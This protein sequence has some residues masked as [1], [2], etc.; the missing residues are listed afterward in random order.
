MILAA[1]R[2]RTRPERRGPYGTTLGVSADTHSLSP[3]AR[4]SVYRGREDP[5]P[6]V[7]A[8]WEI[9]PSF[10]SKAQASSICSGVRSHLN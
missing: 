10:L 1:G 6:G 7:R 2:A 8:A 4:I 3:L 5:A 9:S